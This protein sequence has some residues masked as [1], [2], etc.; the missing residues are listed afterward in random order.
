MKKPTGTGYIRQHIPKLLLFYRLSDVLLILLALYGGVWVYGVPWSDRYLIAALAAMT[1]F[2]LFGANLQVYRSWRGA[3]LIEQMMPLLVNWLLTV[4]ALLMAAYATKTTADYSRVV[5][6]LWMITFPLILTLW[7]WIIRATLGLFRH[8]GWNSR[9]VAIVG[10]NEQSNQL[11][12]LIDTTPALGLRLVGFFDDGGST[13]VPVSTDLTAR[14][15]GAFDDLAERTRQGSIDFVYIC[16][17]LRAEDRIRELL[18]KLSDSTSSVYL[19]PDFFAYDLLQSRLVHLGTLLTISIFES[20]FRGIEGLHKRLEDIILSALILPV[21]AI[22]LL[23]IAIG[24]KLSSPGPV[25]FQ[26]RRYGLDGCEIR[27]WKFRTMTICEDGEKIAQARKDDWRVTRFGL[28]LRRT[29]LDELPQ[30]VNVLMGDMS[31]VGPR[32][33]AVAHNEEYRK[34]IPGYMLRHK[35]KP[36]ITGW[37]QVNGWRGE[38]ASLLEMQKRIECDLW[39][40]RNW[41]I[42]LDLKIIGKTILNGFVSK[43]AY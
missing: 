13:R 10:V 8:R 41:S 34:L 42:W 27:V 37:A 1:L 16:L 3:P 29:S 35:V 21:V 4:F 39:Y 33:H 43:R 25:I 28:F 38:I 2:L 7:R 22:P 5:I 15:V 30:F 36:G 32:P 40:I 23:L 26:Q 24:I 18:S 31:V 9:T 20:P 14:H 12:K 17:P 6:G 11:A 19:V